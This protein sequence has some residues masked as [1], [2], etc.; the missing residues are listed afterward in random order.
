MG[1]T[2]PLGNLIMMVNACESL[3]MVSSTE[4]FSSFQLVNQRQTKHKIQVQGCGSSLLREVFP[5]VTDGQIDSRGFV[6]LFNEQKD[7]VELN[8]QA[9]TS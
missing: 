1:H 9:L 8:N 2:V 3:M 6:Q 7:E 4:I 5:H